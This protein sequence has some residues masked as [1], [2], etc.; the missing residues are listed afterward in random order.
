MFR[1]QFLSVVAG[2]IPVPSF[3]RR[4]SSA[5]PPGDVPF[6]PEVWREHMESLIAARLPGVVFGPVAAVLARGP[7]RI[8]PRVAP[9]DEPQ[10]MVYVSFGV[11]DM[12]TTQADPALIDRNLSRVVTYVVHWLG[13]KAIEFGDRPIRCQ[14]CQFESFRILSIDPDAVLCLV[15][16]EPASRPTAWVQ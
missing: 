3:L 14:I 4:W 16:C 13:S 15:A 6:A 11:K 7:G 10:D 1:R 9:P 2:L 8:K 5:S 12:G